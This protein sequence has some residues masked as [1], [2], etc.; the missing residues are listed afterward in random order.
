[1]ILGGLLDYLKVESDQDAQSLPKKI[2]DGVFSQMVN[3]QSRSADDPGD[4]RIDDEDYN[5]GSGVFWRYLLGGFRQDAAL[6]TE[7]LRLVAA[8]PG[9]NPIYN[10]G[11]GRTYRQ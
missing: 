2:V 4:E 8:D 7:V 10:S 11:R 5:C 1:M 3:D 9:N 6:R